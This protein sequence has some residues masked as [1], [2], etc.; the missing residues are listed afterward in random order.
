MKMLLTFSAILFSISIS[1]AQAKTEIPKAF[2]KGNIVLT[3]GA[4]INGYIKENIRS[5]ASVMWMSE[6]GGK[7]KNYTGGEIISA[8][9]D[10]TKFICIRGDFFKVICEGELSFLQKSSDASSKPSYNGTETIFINGTQGRP[11][12]YFIYDS[13]G[14][15]LQLVTRKTF[16]NVVAASFANCTAAI[17][18][19]KT[20]GDDMY[21]LKEAVEI[22]NTRNNK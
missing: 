14:K 12:D 16:D 5:N 21:Q 11:G 22:Y 9:I 10:N 3:D 8:E 19:A 13:K 1:H 20:I 7:K 4:V 15:Q 17:D 18:K 2:K 6:P